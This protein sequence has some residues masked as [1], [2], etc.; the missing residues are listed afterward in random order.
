MGKMASLSQKSRDLIMSYALQRFPQMAVRLVANMLKS[1]V[2]QIE[3][4][5]VD[6]D[7]I[8][9]W[10]GTY[11]KALTEEDK[12]EWSLGVGEA[13][14][15]PPEA[16]PT[17][18]EIWRCCFITD[19]PFTMRQARWAAYLWKAVPQQS[20][21]AIYSR[22][23]NYALREQIAPLS[24]GNRRNKEEQLM[25]THDL[26]ASLLYMVVRYDI[27]FAWRDPEVSVARILGV[28]PQLRTDIPSEL[29]QEEDRRW[30]M[31]GAG[32]PVFGA[33]TEAL[34]G[35]DP[36]TRLAYL[37]QEACM[38][39]YEG[40]QKVKYPPALKGRLVAADNLYTLVLTRIGKTEKWE[41]MSQEERREAA[42]RLAKA[43][44]AY[45]TLTERSRQSFQWH[46]PQT[47]RLLDS[48]A[49]FGLNPL[50]R[51]AQPAIRR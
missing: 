16:V 33:Q 44:L 11:R 23:C 42:V 31:R 21:L 8:A 24:G 9:K 41:K 17:L 19:T 22:A 30:R 47:R 48:L 32:H 20:P 46:L 13:K 43:A 37:A 4:R 28:I 38:L 1:Q 45:I 3:G 14:S 5:S 36:G 7:T 2:D 12:Q 40:G 18:L 39:R 10:I 27:P 50:L 26:D 49:E 51:D 29:K 34:L 35:I 6:R 25:G 15:I